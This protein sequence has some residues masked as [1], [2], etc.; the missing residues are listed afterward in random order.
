M[1][2]DELRY[3]RETVVSMVLATDFEKHA[4]V[5]SKFTAL[6][7]SNSFMEA[8]DEHCARRRQEAT[9]HTLTHTPLTHTHRSHTPLTHAHRD[10]R[11]E[12]RGAPVV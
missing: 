10:L 8:G 3:F 1:P 2:T 12:C 7:S 6:V 5:L 4:S 11:F 9:P